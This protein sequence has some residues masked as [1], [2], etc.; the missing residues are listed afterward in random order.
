MGGI[1]V[2]TLTGPTD[3]PVTLAEAKAHLRVDH[4]AEDA[5]IRRLIRAA[6]LASERYTGCLWLA[7]TVELGY[8]PAEVRPGRPLP[9]PVAPLRAVVAVRYLDGAGQLQ[10][11]APE[12]YQSRLASNPPL[13]APAR[14]LGWPTLDFTAL[15]PFRV[16][17]DAGYPSRDQV[18]DDCKAAILIAVAHLYAE[19][20]DAP[21]SAD[22]PATSRRL[23]DLLGPG[24]YH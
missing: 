22:L 20:G 15:E 10:T 16:E 14:G 3:E 7:Q 8:P 2:R 23:L 24:G 4:D 17:V 6:R 12:R 13:L 18:P 11:L 21:E 5:L 9:L 19:R 1:S